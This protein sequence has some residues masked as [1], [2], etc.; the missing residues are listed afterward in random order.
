MVCMCIANGSVCVGPPHNQLIAIAH[1]AL[2]EETLKATHRHENGRVA[3]DS[4]LMNNGP[5]V[6]PDTLH[7]WVVTSQLYVL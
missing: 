4:V 2:G 7:Y 6:Q 3:M 1:G 5:S